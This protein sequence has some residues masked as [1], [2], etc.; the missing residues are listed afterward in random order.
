LHD[1]V[2]RHLRAL[3]L[4]LQPADPPLAPWLVA[5][6]WLLHALGLLLAVRIGHRPLWLGLLP[7]LLLGPALLSWRSHHLRLIPESLAPLAIAYCMLALRLLVAALARL[8]SGTA[9]PLQ[10][11]QPWGA[12]LD[13]DLALTLAAV[14]S[15]LAQATMMVRALRGR[16]NLAACFGWAAAGGVLVWSALALMRIAAHGVT[17]SDPYAYV[18][19]A[20][21]LARH[22]SPLHVFP[23]APQIAAWGLS[24]WPAVPV[25]Y[26]PPDPL[27]GLSASVWPPGQAALL[28]VGYRLAG[29]AGLYV[30]TPLLGLASLLATGWLGLLALRAWPAGRRYLAAG[31]A[32]LILGTSYLQVRNLA[33][34]MADAG[35]QLFTTLA[36]GCALRA[37]QRGVGL[38]WVLLA[39]LALGA[40]TAVRYTQALV[41]LPVLA[42]IALPLDQERAPWGEQHG[43][44]RPPR[45]KLPRFG[46][47][48]LL[49]CVGAAGLVLLPVLGYH[50]VAFGGPLRVGSA[51]LPLLGLGNVPGA[52]SNV[53]AE[54]LLSNEF[55]LLLPFLCLG[56]VVVW[57]T[58]RRAG[59][60]LMV[61][62]SA[63]VAFHLL[64]SALRARDLLSVFPVLAL[65]S[66][67]GLA[68]CLAWAGGLPGQ[69]R[70][71]AVQV[72]LAL[73]IVL[74][75]WARTHTTLDLATGRAYFTTFGYLQREQR[76]AFDRVAE[77]T[78]ATAV[79]AASLSAGPLELYAGR[80]AVRPAYWSED[81]WLAFLRLALAAD[82]PIYILADGAE[83]AE[84]VASAG[85][86][87]RLT[88]VASL[89]LPLFSPNGGSDDSYVTLFRLDAAPAR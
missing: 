82:R 30:V 4:D 10:V 1:I 71:Q 12:W 57:R 66:G 42:A 81:E 11:P 51:E 59:G 54:L 31:A 76:R 23:L 46:G 3:C 40:A 89:P 22:G 18:Q 83:L 69:A 68:S 61:W 8:T 55:L 6:L 37:R 56:T 24:V 38:P 85:V 45:A 25:G 70:R 29:E 47:R 43:A 77:L 63:L 19:M 20:V 52:L 88:P 21:D 75:L 72:G 87:Y 17:A 13:L 50:Q 5:G 73:L 79:V 65:W 39:G 60:V 27:T 86:H 53:T 28:A 62:L 26:R 9:G 15:L 36:I 84:R 48:E 58:S 44:H 80:S 32:M 14:W 78:P 49:V 7:V 67:A 33:V 74:S 2:D 41:A 34:P 35:A 64:Y 16:L